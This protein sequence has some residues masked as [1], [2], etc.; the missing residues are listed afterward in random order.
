MTT[1]KKFFIIT[2]SL[3]GLMWSSHTAT[4]QD[5]AL[6]TAM[7]NEMLPLVEKIYNA[8]TDNERYNANEQFAEL[9]SDALHQE[10][11]FFWS[12]DFGKSVS[13]LTSSDKQFRIITWPVLRD[14]GEYECFGLLQ[15]WN[16]KKEEYDVYVL[17]DKSDEAISAEESVF[18]PENWYGC[19][20]QDLI[21][22]KHEGRIYYTLLG[23]T[24]VD[25]LTQRQVIEPLAFKGTNGE[26]VFGQP[27]FR[28]DKNRR[29][30]ILEYASTAMVNLRY[31]NQFVDVEEVKKVKKNGRMVNVR[32]THQ[33]KMKMIIFD[34]VAPQIPGMEGLYQY[35]L[36]TGT[37]MAY[38]FVNGRWE[39]NESAQGRVDNPKLNKEFEP[40]PKS[41]PTYK[42]T[43][44]E[45]EEKN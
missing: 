28:R 13:V 38:I 22:I 16:E 12:W 44:K 18:G 39:L 20:Y 43:L 21:E 11:S 41:A 33:E 7:Q 25:A 3:T 8:P 32:E 27:V 17:N 30:L 9:L 19:V 45:T 29:R 40:L 42:V 1:I 26:P 35:Y 37:E 24:R 31:E 14:D 4:A 10:N 6:F 5:K 23:W 34:E 36:P 15:S 2:I